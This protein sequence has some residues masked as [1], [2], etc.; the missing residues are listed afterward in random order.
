[1]TVSKSDVM[2]DRLLRLRKRILQCSR[3]VA[4]SWPC[5]H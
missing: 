5:C 4:E 2:L 3:I 1:M